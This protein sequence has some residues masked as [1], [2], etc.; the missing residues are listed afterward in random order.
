MEKTQ[1]KVR[2]LLLVATPTVTT[3]R[4]CATEPGGLRVCTQVDTRASLASLSSGN[5][6]IRVTVSAG[7]RPENAFTITSYVFDPHL[8]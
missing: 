8:P 7:E 1:Q 6:R 5:A 4:E 3:G 2:A